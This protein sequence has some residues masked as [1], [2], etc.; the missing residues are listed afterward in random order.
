MTFAF[1]KKWL[2]TAL[3]T[4]LATAMTV[5]SSEVMGVSTSFSASGEATCEAIGYGEELDLYS[6]WKGKFQVQGQTGFMTTEPT[7]YAEA[8]AEAKLHM[9]QSKWV[10][11]HVLNQGGFEFGK[12]GQF[13]VFLGRKSQI[14]GQ[15][16][17]YNPL[18][19]A[20]AEDFSRYI[21]QDLARRKISR[22]M[23]ELRLIFGRFELTSL[24]M[25]G[26][27]S[28]KLPDEDGNYCYGDCQE[29]SIQNLANDFRSAGLA[30]TIEENDEEADLLIEHATRL[31]GSFD[32]FDLGLYVFYI[33]QRFPIY[34]RTLDP[35]GIEF[36]RIYPLRLAFGADFA[37][38]L[39][40]FGSRGEV[41]Y[42]TEQNYYIYPEG[43]DYL[44]D[45]DGLKQH[46]EIE[47][48]IGLDR[49]FRDTTYGN[50]QIAR[51]Y[52]MGS[53]DDLL[54]PYGAIIATLAARETF[55]N[56]DLTIEVRI[57]SELERVGLLFEPSA[58]YLVDQTWSLGLK[59]YIFQGEQYSMLGPYH[60]INHALASITA[61]F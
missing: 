18:D 4:I 11:E 3:A 27:G 61:K 42:R 19:Q 16:D 49:Q 38:V 15:A 33:S 10:N 34:R 2:Q 6:L 25:P 9:R 29:F 41:I 22:E 23:I 1:H 52:I 7:W 51:R 13:S 46:D 21:T 5:H 54:L 53:T 55:W 8:S 48:I 35:T 26:V 36:S 30:T 50:I 47:G 40:S 17:G 58:T 39:G 28:H 59:A 44:Q 60:H 45:R 20:T 56:E 57:L 32:G 12:R 37:A 24:T 14:W 43:E 31:R